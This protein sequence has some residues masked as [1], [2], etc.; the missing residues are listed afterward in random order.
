MWAVVPHSTHPGETLGCPAKSR[1]FTLPA[2]H[3][4]MPAASSPVRSEAR[5]ANPVGLPPFDYQPRTRVVF[6]PGALQRL[7]DLARELG[8]ARVLLVS[9]QGLGSAGHP[10]RA[11]EVLTRAGLQV[12]LFDEVQPNPTTDDVDRG[13]AV[14]RAAAIDLIVGLGGGS[15]MDC[16]KGIN[17]LLTNGGVMAD[18]KGTGRAT[19]PMLPMIA[20]PTTSGTGSEAQSYALIADAATHM[21]MACGDP[22]AACKIALLDPEL[23]LS[24]PPA[25]TAATGVD[26]L[27][28]AVES[29][30]CTRRN[31]VST[32][33][34]EQSFQLLERGL[35]QVLRAPR[36][37]VARS[38]MLLGAHLAGAAIENSML[39]ATHAL[40]N[41]LS[42]HCGLTHGVAIGVMLPHVV[43]YNAPAVN[44]LY[45]RLA[46]L[47][48]LCEAGDARAGE[49]LAEHLRQLVALAG[50]P[51]RL[52]ECGVDRGL[53]PVMAHEATQQWTGTFNP[54]P[55]AESDFQ[56]LYE[57]AW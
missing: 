43:R 44:G 53:F 49:R 31:T 32:L 13:L 6:A 47:A 30:V 52:E 7:G 22:K 54:R 27:S 15:S 1:F 35:P 17:F 56:H 39:G 51:G 16:A 11:T 9:D 41:P 5:P 38:E 24:M 25:V 20:V 3:P 42:A 8:G 18:Y 19:R 21:K 29:Y 50:L 36:E 55:L 48:G 45:G 14:A 26:A 4:L 10:Q 40:A 46:N 57:H 37:L 33:F 28:H 2:A 23:T 34:A 12:T